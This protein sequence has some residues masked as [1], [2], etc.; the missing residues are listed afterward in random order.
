M[1]GN[2]TR[3]PDDRST[4]PSRA[5]TIVYYDLVD[6]LS[7]NHIMALHKD[8]GTLSLLTVD[9]EQPVWPRLLAQEQFTISEMNI[10]RPLLDAYPNYCP[11]EVIWASFNTGQTTNEVVERARIRLHEA[12]FAGVWDYEMRPVRN[13]L[14]R[15]RF[16]LRRTGLDVRSILETGYMLIRLPRKAEAE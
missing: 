2:H 11:H 8:L 3:E 4:A 9:A 6:L 15:T 16:K 1:N 5:E 7:P 12:Q 14:S 13:I 10:L